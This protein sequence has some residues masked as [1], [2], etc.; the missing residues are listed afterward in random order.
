[1]EPPDWDAWAADL[2]SRLRRAFLARLGPERGSEALSIALAYA[3][4]HRTRVRSLDNPA[5]YLFRLGV[6][7][8]RDR[9]R[10][11]LFPPAPRAA[12]PDFEPGLPAA[13][14]ALS[15]SQ[16][17]AVLLVYAYGWTAREVAE[18]QGISVSS[19]ETHLQRG[20]RH[21]RHRLGV[22]DEG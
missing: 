19:V 7:G 8:V 3:W 17:V 18:I 4:E 22:R 5:G 10:H 2:T 1:M 13:I 14:G 6:R 12:L 11:P 20:M 15:P 21:L 16:R 9:R